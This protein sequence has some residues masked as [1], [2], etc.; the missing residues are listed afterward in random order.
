MTSLA[1]NSEHWITNISIKQAK[2][3][4]IA[5]IIDIDLN[6]IPKQFKLYPQSLLKYQF[7][8]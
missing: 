3:S 2:P 4:I 1:T 5:S 6:T 8:I 7:D